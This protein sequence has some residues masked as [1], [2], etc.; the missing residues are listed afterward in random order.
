MIHQFAELGKFFLQRE[1]VTD[2]LLQYAADPAAKFGSQVILALVFSANGFERVQV[3]EYDDDRR[4]RLL[5]RQGPPN[6][7]DA[8]PTTGMATV[9]KGQENTAD[10]DIG[11]KLARLAR[12]IGDARDHSEDLP[13]WECEALTVMHDV[14]HPPEGNKLSAIDD[15]R[16]AVIAALRSAH[17]D[18]KNR[19]ILTV[20]WQVPGEEIRWVGDFKAFQQALVRQGTDAGTKSKGIEGDVKGTG[21]CCICG[22]R[23]TEV[24]G[25]LK[26]THPPLYTLDKPGSVAGGFNPLDAWQNFPACRSCCDAVDY[27]WERI[28]K[29]LSFNYYGFKYLLLPSPVRIAPTEAYEWMSR[30]VSAR[31]SRNA[32]KRLTEAEDELLDLIA[33]ENNRLQVDLL[34]YQPDPQSFRPQLYVS[35]LLPSRFRS[36]FD[37]QQRADRHQWFQQPSPRAFTDGGFTFGCFREIFPAAHGGSTF[38]DDFLSATRY[39]LELRGFP[40]RRLLEIGMRW[41]QQDYI[42]GS[43]WEYRLADL[44]RCFIFF[45]EIAQHQKRSTS[46]NPIDYGSSEQADRV[47][48]CFEQAPDTGKLRTDP[49]AQATFLVGAC[50]GRI[51]T[52]Q[53]ATRG[54]S[55]FAGK[56]KGFR[57]GQQDIQGLFVAAK[58]KAKAYGEEAERTVNGL[59]SCAAA[60]LAATPDRWSLSPDEISYF[61]ALG[62]ALRSRLAKERERETDPQ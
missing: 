55:P 3:E 20:A 45:E 6:G 54:S 38:D 18:L 14:M 2:Q 23:E 59:L 61:F 31:M 17:P 36:L 30:L 35:G 60:A 58:D 62:H 57:L 39:A 37:G 7:W 44:L 16:S 52:I 48:K 10:A 42:D 15:H 1:A 27:S 26:V 50:C 33:D 41:V 25:L 51:E 53:Q 8:T 5:Y 11:K 9:K 32:S 4:L 22:K 49:G 21:Q 56:Y 28:K 13:T 40:D 24:S 47:R 29:E 34:F 43:K 12:S 19:A 46:L